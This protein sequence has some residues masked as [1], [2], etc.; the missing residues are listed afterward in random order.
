MGGRLRWLWQLAF[1]G[2]S[3]VCQRL[4][5]ISF[6]IVEGSGLPTVAACTIAHAEEGD[7]D[8]PLGLGF[9]FE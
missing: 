4:G 8:D 7:C 3:G 1:I 9:N 2:V 5:T 6:A